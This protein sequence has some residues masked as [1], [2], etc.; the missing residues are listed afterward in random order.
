MKNGSMTRGDTGLY[1][2]YGNEPLVDGEGIM[3]SWGIAW[4]KV[5]ARAWMEQGG[6]LPASEWY[7]KLM[8][9]HPDRVLDA[10][11][12]EG[13]IVNAFSRPT[14]EKIEECK[15]WFKKNVKI[16]ISESSLDLTMNVGGK[17]TG[18]LRKASK[19]MYDV[20]RT[21]DAGGG[22]RVNGWKNVNGLEHV[23]VL[24]LP[25]KPTVPNCQAV[26]SADYVATGKIYPFTCCC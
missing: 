5:I 11:V 13:F 15:K 8:S 7:E 25:P 18:V 16:V 19:D 1:E 3:L 9:K 14:N 26:A 12:E 20:E 24:T 21:Q 4:P 2:H 23:L 17:T 22:I 10:L 6:D